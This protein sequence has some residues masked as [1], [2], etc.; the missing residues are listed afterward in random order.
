MGEHGVHTREELLDSDW[1]DRAIRVAVHAERL[2][3]LRPG[4]YAETGADPDVARAVRLGGA[5]SCMS[6][7]AREKVWVPESARGLHVRLCRRKSSGPH[8]TYHACGSGLGDPPRAVDDLETAVRAVVGCIRGDDLV[9]VLDS[10]LHRKLMQPA[11]LAGVLR[12][13][14]RRVHRALAAVDGSADSGTETRVRLHVRRKRLEYRTQ[15]FLPGVGY[16]D[17]LVGR[18]LVIECDSEEHHSGQA[19]EADRERDLALH[20]LGFEVLRL[21]YQ[22]VFHQ[23][24]KVE[25]AIARK[26]VAGD[27][28]RPVDFTP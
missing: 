5:L 28:R 12:E 7:L 24:P 21:S 27:H 8:S 22:Q 3:R 20:I 23:F 17:I 25:A 2:E 13:A 16:V 10:I 14:P 9:A 6:V 26:I 4:W 18:S 15:V 11:E 19:I 1:T